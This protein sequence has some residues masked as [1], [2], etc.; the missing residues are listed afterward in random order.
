[1]KSFV[2]LVRGLS[3]CTLIEDNHR[4]L[5]PRKSGA[6]GITDNRRNNPF[7]YRYSDV[8]VEAINNC[9]YPEE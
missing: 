6:H 5:L 8:V 3:E 7:I 2:E 4:F 1:M 9:P